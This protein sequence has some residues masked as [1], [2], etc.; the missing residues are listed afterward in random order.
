[1]SG[2]HHNHDHPHDHDHDHDHGDAGWLAKVRHVVRPH[3]HDTADQVDSALEGSREGIRA[4]WISLGV[5][6]VTAALQAVVVVFSGSVALLG[7][8]LHN[9]A[10]ALTAVP[11]FIAFMVGRR[12]PTR[13]YTYGYGRAED[14]AGIVIV[15]FIA[16]SAGVRRLRGGTAAA[17]TRRRHVPAGRGRRRRDRVPRQRDRGPVPHQR[18][19]ADRLRRAGRRRAARP[20]RRV[21]LARRARQR[22]RPRPGLAVGGPGRRSRH[23]RRDPRGARRRRAAGLPAADGR[24]RPGSSWTRWSRRCAKRTACSTSVMPDCGGSVTG[25]APSARSSSTTR[26]ASSRRTTS[27]CEAEHSIMHAVPR[28][29]SAL[30]HAD[31][32]SRDGVDRH[33]AVAHHRVRGG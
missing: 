12:L 25:C 16:A 27:R 5:L 7:D 23:H 26:S 10:D 8:T 32:Q 31:P 14:L 21:H 3:S 6:G 33:S 11:L 2:D 22:R 20:H 15:V 28:L 4:V 13:R 17:R 30:V 1:M 19:A 24:G 29:D 18:R 9:V